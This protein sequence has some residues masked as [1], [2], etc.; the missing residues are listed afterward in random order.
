MSKLNR[1]AIALIAL[2]ALQS[3]FLIWMIGGRIALL[4]SAT[5]VTLATEPVDPRD[6]FRGDYVI[7]NYE[8]SRLKPA[9]LNAPADLKGNDTVYVTLAP[10]GEVWQA[11][12]MSRSRPEPAE[13]KA[14]IR[15]RIIYVDTNAPQPASG[16]NRATPCPR[17]GEATIHYG[18]ESFFVPEGEGKDLEEARNE[19]RLMVDVA[20][21][22]DGEAAIKSLKLDGKPLYTE[23][24]F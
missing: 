19:R 17:C 12:A 5:T 18:I 4:N 6:I 7:L 8:I 13:G 10:Q 2:A 22:D 16:K 11:I 14:V 21:A 3:L 15:G 9:D 20:I 23:S 1:F 24:L